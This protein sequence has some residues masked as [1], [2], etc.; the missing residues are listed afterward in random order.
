MSAAVLHI[1]NNLPYLE[2]ISVAPD[3]NKEQK[4][5]RYTRQGWSG[6][7]AFIYNSSDC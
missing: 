3:G 4:Y 5:V 7:W 1:N 2:Q 6:A